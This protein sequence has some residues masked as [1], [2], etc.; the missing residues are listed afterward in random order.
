MP[1]HRLV[2]HL[3]NFDFDR[4][5]RNLSSTFDWY[6]YPFANAEERAAAYA[7][8]RKDL[9]GPNHGRRAIGVYPGAATLYGASICSC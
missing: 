1:T 7:E 6:S 2:S 9:E 3:A 5:R 8:F 4:F